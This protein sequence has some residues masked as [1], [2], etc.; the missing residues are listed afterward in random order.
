[1]KLFVCF[2]FLLTT[3]LGLAAQGPR[4]TR[5]RDGLVGPVK[6]LESGIINYAV[7]DGKRV[8]G[9]SQVTQ[10]LSFD[11]RGNLTESITFD[12]TTGTINTRLV[13]TYDVLGRNTGYDE[14]Y[15]PANQTVAKPR[16]H[17]DTL[18]H[19]DRVV[20]RILYEADGTAG[21]RFTYKYDDKGNKLEEA[22]YAWTGSR[23][24]RITYTHDA[25]G[26]VLT[27]TN[28]DGDD[29]VAGKTVN[30]Y[31]ANGRTVEW[32]RYVKDVLRYKRLFTYDNRG[33]LVEEETFEFNAPP[34]VFFTHAPVPGKVVY[35]YDDKQ[36]SKEIATYDPAGALKT[37]EVR[38]VDAHGNQVG[39]EFYNADGSARPTEI[40]FYEQQK[41]LGKLAG[42]SHT[43]FQYDAHGNWTKQ[44]HLILPDGATE[45]QPYRA[46]Y[47]NIT[48]YKD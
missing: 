26:R 16:K 42:K 23:I 41:L 32:V 30:S 5:A 8:E 19:N 47:R 15:R 24:G 27:E 4:P 9:K 6:T 35:T 2:L 18:D 1:M 21:G 45:P 20:E 7:K 11:E 40:N 37:R 29:T 31:D 13:F 28:Y 38:T 14:Y 44:I 25:A 3:S 10:K 48:Y 39:W 36:R 12:P 17:I 22:F 43:Q 33:R 34:G 46:D